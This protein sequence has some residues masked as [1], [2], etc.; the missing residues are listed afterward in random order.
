MPPQTS[1]VLEAPGEELSQEE[2]RCLLSVQE[3]T[4]DPVRMVVLL[5]TGCGMTN[6]LPRREHSEKC[7]VCRRPREVA[8]GLSQRVAE[9]FFGRMTAT[10]A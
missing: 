1:S 9:G 5:E 6:L 3:G 7:P 2:G 4:D 8:E 10:V